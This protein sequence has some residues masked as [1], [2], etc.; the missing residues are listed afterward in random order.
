[1]CRSVLV[2]VPCEFVLIVWKLCVFVKASCEFVLIA[3][4]PLRRSCVS[5]RSRCGVARICFDRRESFAE[6]VRVE[7]LSFGF[8]LIA[9][10]PR[11]SFCSRCG[12]VRFSCSRNGFLEIVSWYAL[13]SQSRG[14]GFDFPLVRSNSG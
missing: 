10:N 5:K 13:L 7:T 8:V 11:R 14:R 6:I 2:V 4:N 3:A 9:A 12:L 1:M